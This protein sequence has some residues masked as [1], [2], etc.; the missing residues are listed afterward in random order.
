M[1]HASYFFT[2]SIAYRPPPAFIRKRTARL[3]LSY[4]SVSHASC[5]C[6]TAY[7]TPPTFIRKRI[8]HLLQSYESVLH[9]SCYYTKAYCTPL[10]IIRKRM[11]GRRCAIRC[12]GLRLPPRRL[13]LPT[14]EAAPT[15][16]WGLDQPVSKGLRPPL[17][18]GRTYLQAAGCIYEGCTYP[19]GGCTYPPRRLHLPLSGA[20]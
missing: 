1:L 15:P 16:K 18:G 17:R 5:Y 13:H 8:A 9:A 11:E 6:T 10:V 19:Q 14:Q 2:P 3:L 12:R 7:C 20:L 4:Y